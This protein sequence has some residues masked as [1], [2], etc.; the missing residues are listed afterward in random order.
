LTNIIDLEIIKSYLFLQ[1]TS[2]N[3]YTNQMVR[4]LLTVIFSCEFCT[5]A[6]INYS[7]SLALVIRTVTFL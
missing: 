4:K 7:E 3:H 5:I 1:S 2:I 6:S